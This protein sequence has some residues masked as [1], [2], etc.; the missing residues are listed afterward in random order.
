MAATHAR[1]SILRIGTLNLLHFDECIDERVQALSWELDAA[2]IR[3][4]LLQEVTRHALES[5]RHG[6]AGWQISAGPQLTGAGDL[7]AVATRDGEH[8]VLRSTPVDF[9]A[10][11]PVVATDHGI[12]AS[13]HLAWGLGRESERVAEA[14]RISRWLEPLRGERPV[15]LGGDFNAEPSSRTMRFLTGLDNVDGADAAWTSAWSGR[16]PFATTRTDGGWAEEQSRRVGI[17]RPYDMPDR[18]IDHL[19]VDGW[20]YG[21]NGAFTRT[22]RFA[23]STIPDGRGISDHYGVGADV[24][25][26]G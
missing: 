21:V 1:E 2:N 12:W 7:Q 22:F 13:V 19:L 17:V 16:E 23:D 20:R 5:L 9:P 15:F 4:L 14:V 24:L 18:T 11:A 25:L 10:I 3:V 8:V 26:L 6:L